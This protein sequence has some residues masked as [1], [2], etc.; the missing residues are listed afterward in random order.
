M[1][2]DYAKSLVSTRIVLAFEHPVEL[3]PD[4]LMTLREAL[5][6]RF[7][8]TF[9]ILGGLSSIPLS[10]IS[11]GNTGLAVA[12]VSG[13]STEIG[14]EQIEVKWDQNFRGDYPGFSTLLAMLEDVYRHFCQVVPHHTVKIVNLSYHH[15]DPKVS[16][17]AANVLRTPFLDPIPP[18][19]K[20]FNVAWDG[21][22]NFEY[23]LI[24]GLTGDSLGFVTVGGT[25]VP[26][27]GNP[28]E[29]LDQIVH[30]SM[31]KTFEQI[32]TDEGRNYYGY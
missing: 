11:G 27:G 18:N 31:L 7:P 23:R 4:A 26:E 17:P 32:L 25:S 8:V 9:R 16:K 28:I 6:E 14:A 22:N 12:N 30:T 1:T 20:E 13:F 21:G 5:R 2:A 10:I 15:L 24:F 3:G 19:I 29:V